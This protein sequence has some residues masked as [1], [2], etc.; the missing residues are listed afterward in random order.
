MTWDAVGA[1]AELIAALG[2]IISLLYLAVQV[3]HT[4]AVLKAD[5]RDRNFQ[6]WIPVVS[7]LA[8][9]RTLAELWETGLAN[10]SSLDLIDQSRFRILLSQ[11]VFHCQVMYLRSVEIGDVQSEDTILSNMK[12]I[13][14][15]A[16]GREF[17]DSFTGRPEFM[18]FIESSLAVPTST[19]SSPAARCSASANP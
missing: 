13:I 12:P 15:S 14:E 1:I 3:K 2:V 9:D 5:S 18:S 4:R 19:R 8:H 10:H 6:N 11:M 7:P 17:W 16:S